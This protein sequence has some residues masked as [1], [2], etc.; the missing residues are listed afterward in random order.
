[1]QDPV[2]HV[3]DDEDAARDSLELLLRSAKLTVVTYASALAFLQSAPQLTDG[4]II[5]DLRMP[6]LDGIGL[7]KRLKKINSKLPVVV[8]T[9][10]GDVAIAVEAMKLGAVDFLE[11]PFDDDALLT[12]VQSALNEW[13]GRLVVRPSDRK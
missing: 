3:I 8:I 7:L 6:D 11:K 4:C 5:T 13:A 9:G 10:H 2:V 1:M 12:A